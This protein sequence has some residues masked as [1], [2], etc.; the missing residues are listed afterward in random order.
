MYFHNYIHREIAFS[1]LFELMAFASSFVIR[2]VC[3]L[4][5]FS[6]VLIP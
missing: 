4:L 6:Y 2:E 1:N 3:Y 5:L